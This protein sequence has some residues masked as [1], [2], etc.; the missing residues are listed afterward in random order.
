[1]VDLYYNEDHSCYAVLVSSGFGAGWS[2]WNKPEFAYDRRI[3][4][5][6][7]RHNSQEFCNK[8]KVYSFFSDA[9]ETP[10]HAEARKFFSSLG[11]NNVYFGGYRSDMLHW[12]PVGSSWRIKEYD[13]SESIEY[14]DSSDWNCFN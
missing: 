13:G 1:M 10:E 14:R 5:W 4:E 7:L 12:V 11:Y 3:V 6:Y 9:S 2:S 8:V